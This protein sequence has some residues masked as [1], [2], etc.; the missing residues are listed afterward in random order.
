MAGVIGFIGLVAPNLV[1]R[2][3]GPGHQDLLIGSGLAGAVLLLLAD[4]CARTVA[5]P[6]EIPVG[7]LTGM[8]GAPIM[9]WTLIQPQFSTGSR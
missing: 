2:F 5:N 8:V 7:L 6:T 9:A 1:R 4:T 3:V